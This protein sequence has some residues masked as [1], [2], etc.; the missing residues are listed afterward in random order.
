MLLYVIVRHVSTFIKAIIKHIYNSCRN[1]AN[2]QH[3]NRP[4]PKRDWDL[5]LT[6]LSCRDSRDQIKNN[7]TIYLKNVLS[8]TSIVEG[9]IIHGLRGIESVINVLSS[10]NSTLL[11]HWKCI[12]P[13][14]VITFSVTATFQLKRHTFSGINKVPKRHVAFWLAQY[15]I[16]RAPTSD[17]TLPVSVPI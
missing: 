17:I 3:N 7:K 6:V 10:N 11:F 14:S 1:N 15:D 9:S 16:R 8:S 13:S 12:Q 4:P 5:N 2:I